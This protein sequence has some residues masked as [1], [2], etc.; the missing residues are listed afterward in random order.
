M[1]LDTLQVLRLA[2]GEQDKTGYLIWTA[3]SSVL[4][5]AIGEQDSVN[6]ETGLFYCHGFEA[7]YRGARLFCSCSVLRLAIGEQD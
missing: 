5:L 4:R 7:S 3:E 6:P 1:F 2:I